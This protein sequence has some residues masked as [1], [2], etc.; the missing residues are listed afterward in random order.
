MKYGNAIFTQRKVEND[1][2]GQ[3]VL[4]KEFNEINFNLFLIS[5]DLKRLRDVQR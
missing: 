1:H 2:S 5:V 4:L 3:L